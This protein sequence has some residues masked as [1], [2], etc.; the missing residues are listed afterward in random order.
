[1]KGDNS[2]HPLFRHLK[3]ADD[4]IITKYEVTGFGVHQILYFIQIYIIKFDIHGLQIMN[5]C[6]LQRVLSSSTA[7][8]W[9]ILSN[10]K[11]IVEHCDGKTGTLF[12]LTHYAEG[13]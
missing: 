1:M 12:R 7:L 3:S 2:W 9:H 10:V 11:Q 5:A 6:N 8:E 4:I 13:F